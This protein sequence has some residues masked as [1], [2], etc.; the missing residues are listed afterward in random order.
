MGKFGVFI[1]FILL[2]LVFLSVEAK[3]PQNHTVKDKIE[4]SDSQFVK[5]KNGIILDKDTGLEWYFHEYDSIGRFAAEKWASGLDVGGGNWRLPNY[6]DIL[7]LYKNRIKSKVL[8]INLEVTQKYMWYK[9]SL[10]DRFNFS[11]GNATQDEFGDSA[12]FAYSIAVRPQQHEKNL[13]S[14]LSDQ[15]ATE[16]GNK[17][18]ITVGQSDLATKQI[19]LSDNQ[20]VKYKNGV[21]W[22]KDT[23]LEWYFHEYDSIGRFAAQKWASDLAVDGGNWRLPYY[24]EVLALYKNHRKSKVLHINLNIAQRYVWYNESLTEKFNFNTGNAS[25]DEY[26]DSTS[27]AYVIAVRSQKVGE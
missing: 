9:E 7:G 8:R 18:S 24:K 12:S 17:H 3:E 21:I 5:Y 13:K 14:K 16:D 20:F 15:N 1:V 19:E 11:T 27:F 25:I 2:S 10:T 22:D 26:G 6:N 4:L 23:G